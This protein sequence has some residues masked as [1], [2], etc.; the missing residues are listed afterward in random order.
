MKRIVLLASL[1]IIGCSPVEQSAKLEFPNSSYGKAMQCLNENYYSL[2]KGMN[3]SDVTNLEKRVKTHCNDTFALDVPEYFYRGTA[4]LTKDSILNL[5]IRPRGSNGVHK[6]FSD[7]KE[8]INH[9]LV[10]VDFEVHLDSKSDASRNSSYDGEVDENGCYD[11]KTILHGTARNISSNNSISGD[12]L[13]TST[14]LG[15]KIAEISAKDKCFK[16][17]LEREAITKSDSIYLD[18]GWS[19]T[20]VSYKG[21]YFDEE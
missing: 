3:F 1:I 13:V 5:K 19:W 11:N 8:T 16:L 15:E 10:S 12:F 14:L 2:K 20:T 9:I 17:W 6:I 21:L 18:K 4:T 7:D